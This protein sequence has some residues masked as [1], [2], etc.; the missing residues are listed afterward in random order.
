M[1][2]RIQVTLEFL[3]DFHIGTGAGLGR[4]VDAV[5]ARTAGGEPVVPGSTIK[6]LARDA[7]AG[8]PVQL[9]DTDVIARVFGRPGSDEGIVRFG[10]AVPEKDWSSPMIHGRS[11]RDRNRGRALDEAL[12]RMED[13]TACRMVA[14]ALSDQILDER[15][16][17]LLITALRRIEAIGGQ[18]RRGKGQVSITVK[19]LEGPEPWRGTQVPGNSS[20]YEQ[21]LRRTLEQA[22]FPASSAPSIAPLPAE[23]PPQVRNSIQQAP[24]VLWVFARAEAP[25]VLSAVSEVGNVSRTLAHV[26]GTSLRGAIA[27]HLIHRGWRPDSHLFRS[28]FVHEEVHFGPLYPCLPW[29]QER[30]LPLPAPASLLTCKYH[31]GLRDDDPMAHGVTNALSRGAPSRCGADPDPAPLVPLGSFLQVEQDGVGESLL[32]SV[33]PITR[34]AAHVGIDPETQRAQDHMLYGVEQIPSGTW[35]AGFLW[36]PASLLDEI[37]NGL[38]GKVIA[39]GKGRTRGHG[40]LVIYLRKPEESRHPVFPGLLFP[41]HQIG[42]AANEFTLTLYSDLIA[43]D[44]LLRPVT[45]LNGRALWSLL[46]GSGEEPFEVVRGYASS[47]TVLG[48]NGVPGRPRTPDVAIVAGSTWRFQWTDEARREEALTRLDRAQRLGIGLRRGE[49][50]GR[51]IVDLPLHTSGLD[52]TRGQEI[53]PGLDVVLPHLPVG[54]RSSTPNRPLPL[55]PLPDGLRPAEVPPADRP[56]LAR[57]LWCAAQEQDPAGCLERAIAARRQRG[58]PESGTDRWLK[59]LVGRKDEASFRDDLRACA[60]ALDI[61]Q[62]EQSNVSQE[63]RHA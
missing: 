19:V 2:T 46:D 34:F 9:R 52:Q 51:V 24:G 8:L 44:H 45:L 15:D 57:L 4:V 30:S 25:L 32:R 29:N 49:G 14:H 63:A 59:V 17:V 6:G 11:A 23:P 36:G 38:D 35:F 28:V 40:D 7:V 37:H 1:R 50:F 10:D 39:V 53:D 27:T 41:S 16:L 33:K 54:R 12:F 31:P 5:I 18:R 47:R 61:E 60:R 58:K 62:D 21:A 3:S 56:G 42:T 13:A 26:P 22:S 20:V 48:F 55:P 43:I